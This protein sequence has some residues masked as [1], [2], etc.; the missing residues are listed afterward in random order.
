MLVR[1]LPLL[2]LNLFSVAIAQLPPLPA[3][4]T[5]ACGPFDHRGDAGYS[6]CMASV[7]GDG[8]RPY[9]IVC[10]TDAT[11]TVPL[12]TGPCRAA[13]QAMCIRLVTGDLKAGGWHWSP[14]NS[15][16]PCR[17]GI[18]LSGMDGAAPVP[19]YKRCLNQIYGTMIRTCFQLGNVAT[20][21]LR[22]LPDYTT[23]FSGETVNAGY[24]AYVVSPKALFYDMEGS[25]VTP[26]VFGSP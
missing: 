6:T 11:I 17:I 20:V 18:F 21:N 12:K 15:A 4:G 13:G 10:G 5:D 1:N 2:C 26:D 24:H 8:P 7:T 22:R 3:P 19:N 16:S 23:N 14:D 9:G 25:A